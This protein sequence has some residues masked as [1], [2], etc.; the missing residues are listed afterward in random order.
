VKER[1]IALGGDPSSNT[2][3]EFAAFIKAENAKYAKVIKD[4]N[5]RAE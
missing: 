3:E 2:P 4:A 5:I 1:L